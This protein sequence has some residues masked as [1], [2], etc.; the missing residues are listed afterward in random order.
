MRSSKTPAKNN[1]SKS[2]RTTDA[3]EIG[4]AMTRAVK[5]AMREHAL[6]GRKV[7]F[8]RDGKI[9]TE[10]PALATKPKRRSRKAA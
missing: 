1:V 6:L 3:E 4:R 7:S 8:M 2:G 5:A 9:V 10:V